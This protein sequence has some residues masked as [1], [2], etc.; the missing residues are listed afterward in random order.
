MSGPLGPRDVGQHLL[1]DGPVLA[2]PVTLVFGGD[3]RGQEVVARVLTLPRDRFV[4]VRDDVVDRVERRELLLA[5]DDRV[6]GLGKRL[7][8]A[9][10]EAER[11][12]DDEGE[13]VARTDEDE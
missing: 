1:L 12:A 7:R 4:G 2:Q 8:E 13:G 10:A 11:G 3:E 9:E 5:R 6:E